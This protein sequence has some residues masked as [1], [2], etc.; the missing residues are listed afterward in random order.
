MRSADV[1]LG[2]LVHPDS[3]SHPGVVM[4]HDVW[5]LSDHTRDLARRLAEEGFSVLALDLYRREREVR[6]EN[7]GEWMRGLSDPQV[8]SDVQAGIDFLAAHPSAAGRGIGV[9]GFCMGGMYALLAACT[10]R[11]ISASVV[12]YGLLS[13]QHGILHAEAGLDPEKKPREP[14]AAVSDLRVPLL[15]LYGDADEFVPLSDIDRLRERLE[16]TGRP[17]DVAVYPGAGHAFMNDTRPDAFRPEIAR[18][19]WARM[20]EFFRK[21]VGGDVG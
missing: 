2:H 19:A 15:A 5:G 9:T 3:G 10:C 6:I 16:A 14:L 18:Q 12:F 1:E 7:P 13:H 8:L 17:A 11:G 21:R 20:L 4:I